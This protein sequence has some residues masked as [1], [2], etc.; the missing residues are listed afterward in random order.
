MQQT[1]SNYA[2]NEHSKITLLRCSTGHCLMT[3]K[4]GTV[5]EAVVVTPY[6]TPNPDNLRFPNKTSSSTTQIN[7]EWHQSSSLIR[8]LNQLISIYTPKTQLPKIYLISILQYC[9][10]WPPLTNLSIKVKYV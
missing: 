10:K 2:S 9:S 7:D 6:D 8:I 5:R 3:I 1:F 4:Y